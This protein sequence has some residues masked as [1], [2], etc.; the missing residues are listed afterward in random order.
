[1]RPLVLVPIGTALGVIVGL[2]IGLSVSSNSTS[3][4][5]P[6]PAVTVTKTPAPK[7]YRIR[8]VCPNGLVRHLTVGG[9]GSGGL[10]C[11]RHQ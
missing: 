7:V 3:T 1:M 5:Q 6:H 8:L 11:E 4:A 10:S 2:L 9:P